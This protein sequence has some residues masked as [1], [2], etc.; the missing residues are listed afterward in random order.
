MY[1]FDSRVRFSETD[2]QGR[3]TLEALMD[4]FQDCSTFQ[5]EDLGVG[6]EYLRKRDEAWVLSYWQ[7]VIEEYPRLGEK[8]QICTLPYDFKGCFGYRNF[9]MENEAGERIACANSLWTLLNMK[10]MFPVKPSQEILDAYEIEEKIPMDYEPRK[11]VVPGE[12][13]QAEEITVRNHHLDVNGH[14]NNGQYVRLAGGYLPEGTMVHQLRVEYRKQA[15]LGDVM[16]PYI[17]EEGNKRIISLCDSEGKPYAVVEFT[18][19]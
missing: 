11:I 12:G 9:F 15:L 16:V 5:S 13:K 19:G 1:R 17:C 18:L 2:T 4:Y 6:F 8:I 10:K 14:V 3:I 7:V